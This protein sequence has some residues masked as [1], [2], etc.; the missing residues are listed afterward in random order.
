MLELLLLVA[1]L[2]LIAIIGAT[3]GDVESALANDRRPVLPAGVDVETVRDVT[4]VCFSERDTN[5]ATADCRAI[6]EVTRNRSALTGRTFLEQL[7]AYSPEATGRVP[8]RTTRHRWISTIEASCDE[9]AGWASYNEWR[10]EHGV[11]FRERDGRRERA[12]CLPPFHACT[13]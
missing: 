5:T 3:C 1:L 11:C 2:I 12:A 10:V 13:R 7:R 4:R 6:I 8:A 9:P